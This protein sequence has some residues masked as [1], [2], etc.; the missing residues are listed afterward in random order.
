MKT[1]TAATNA[2]AV[3][4]PCP[5]PSSHQQVR[6]WLEDFAARVRA[7]DYD[8]GRAMLADDVVGF[9]TFARML[10]GLDA[11]VAGQWKQIWGCTRNFRFLLDEAHVVVCDELAWI[12]TP[13][14]SQGR[15]EHGGWFDRHGRCTLILRRADHGKWLCCHSHY[16]RLPTPK[17]TANGA[18]PA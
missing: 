5:S 4:E 2:A 18:T 13:W 3:M 1:S 11:L 15:D 16:S 12:A 9:G 7:A 14:H 6:R 10:V 17:P 8:G